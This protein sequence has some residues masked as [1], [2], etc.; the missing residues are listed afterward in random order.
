MTSGWMVGRVSAVSLLA[1]VTV[2]AGGCGSDLKAENE[3]LT[4]QNRELQ[5]QLDAAN[6][7]LAASQQELM[8]RGDA[9]YTGGTGFSDIDGITVSQGPG[10]EVTVRV[11]GDVLFSSGKV[12]L[13]SSAKTTLSQIAAV[14]KSDYAGRTVRIEGYTDT[15][16]IR[17]SKWKDNLELSSMRAMAVQRHLASQGVPEDSMYSAGMHTRNQQ[18]S[19]AQSRRVEIVVIMN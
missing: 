1:I 2:F 3:A 7:A 19:K 5:A 15:D 16:P 11:P 17:K 18:A 10:G 8:A 4:I 12:D 13:K 14:L 6:D 9:Q